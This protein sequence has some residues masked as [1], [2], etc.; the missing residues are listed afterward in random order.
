[1][2]KKWIFEFAAS[3]AWLQRT[4]RNNHLLCWWK[5]HIKSEVNHPFTEANMPRYSRIKCCNSLLTTTTT[6]LSRQWKETEYILSSFHPQWRAHQTKQSTV[7]LYTLTLAVCR[8]WW[9]EFPSLQTYGITVVRLCVGCAALASLAT[10][11][12]LWSCAV[13]IIISSPTAAV[14]LFIV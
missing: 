12:V 5:M 9:Q 11:S 3:I 2:L 7:W 13:R 4:L 8:Y 1:M 6:K 10:S 14:R